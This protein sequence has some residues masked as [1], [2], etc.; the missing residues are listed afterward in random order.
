MRMSVAFLLVSVLGPH[1]ACADT[2]GSAEWLQEGIG[3]RQ[4]GMG[5]AARAT[6]GDVHAGSWNP[7]GLAAREPEP[8]SV[9]SMITVAGLG[10]SVASLSVARQTDTSGTFAL[11]WARRTIAGLERVDDQGS[12]TETAAGADDLAALSWGASPFYQLRVGASL[13]VLHQQLFDFSSTGSAA[14]LG[15]QVQPWLDH[16]IEV[17]VTLQNAVSFQRWNTGTTNAG[18]RAYGAGAAWRTWHDRVTVAADV[19][20]VGGAAAPAIHA[21]A[22]VWALDQLAGRAGW[23]DGRPAAG[24]TYLWKPYQL[25]YGIE[26][27]RQHLGP[28]HQVSFLLHF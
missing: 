18:A 26:L 2:A 3:A 10:R 27:D 28:I 25:D 19:V 11:T 4:L 20:S 7:A 17:G 23:N 6:A 21:G 5:G 24:L 13:K 12:V 8:W 16:D 9:G 14:D 1:P 22:E 15:V